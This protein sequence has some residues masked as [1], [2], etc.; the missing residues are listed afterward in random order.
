VWVFLKFLRKCPMFEG[1][2]IGQHNFL[3]LLFFEFIL[4][5]QKKC[6]L[7]LLDSFSCQ[8]YAI[9]SLFDI[10]LAPIFQLIVI[11]TRNGNDAPTVSGWA[12]S[13]SNFGNFPVATL[14]LKKNMHRQRIR[15]IFDIDFDEECFRCI[16][17]K[18]TVLWIAWS[19]FSTLISRLISHNFFIFYKLISDLLNTLSIFNANMYRVTHKWVNK[20]FFD[21]YL[22]ERPL[23]FIFI[24]HILGD[25]SN[26][27]SI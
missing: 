21:F 27:C 6:H 23:G 5:Y 3:M 22:I 10:A 11:Y 2:H 12:Q 1:F 9:C 18:P 19:L 26:R 24:P 8:V 4:F 7:D 14:K 13:Q 17:E 25:I 16:K 15:R 20:V